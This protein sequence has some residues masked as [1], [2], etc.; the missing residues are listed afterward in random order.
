MKKGLFPQGK[1]RNI[2]AVNGT[3]SA[4]SFSR[5]A[6]RQNRRSGC[7]RAAFRKPLC[8]AKRAHGPT[9]TAFPA[10]SHTT[11]LGPFGEVVRAT[12]PMAKA[13]A[14]VLCGY[15]IEVTGYNYWHRANFLSIPGSNN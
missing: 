3:P 12:G 4:S 7:S 15:N 1:G 10:K 2:S 11:T 5:F 9:K 14:G 8:S 13:K 6:D